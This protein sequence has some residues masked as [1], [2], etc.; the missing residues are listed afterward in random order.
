METRKTVLGPEHPDT[1]TSMWNLSYTLKDLRRH[2][3]ALSMLQACVQF[4]T[5]DWVLPSDTVEATA[6]LKRWQKTFFKILHPRTSFYQADH[7][8]RSD[9]Y[10]SEQSQLS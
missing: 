2:D 1:L 7:P 5:N 4:Q 3:E 9:K 6:A 10:I 8:S